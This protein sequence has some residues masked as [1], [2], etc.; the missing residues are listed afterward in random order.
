VLRKKKKVKKS[1]GITTECVTPQTPEKPRSFMEAEE[2]FNSTS[3]REVSITT[4][5]MQQ[6]R[7]KRMMTE[8]NTFEFALDDLGHQIDI[9]TKFDSSVQTFA[10]LQSSNSLK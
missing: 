1:P 3:P 9:L 5:R 6:T 2:Y 7:Q 8:E 4:E 10:E